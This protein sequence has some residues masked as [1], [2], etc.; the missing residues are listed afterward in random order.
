[1]HIFKKVPFA[2]PP[3]GDLRFALPKPPRRWEEVWNSKEYGPACMS[4]SSETSSP[5]KWVD[6]D[7]LHLNVFTSEACLESKNCAVAYYLHGGAI[8]FDS[9]VMFNDTVVI[10]AF[11]RKDVVIVVGAYRLGVFSHVIFKNES[12]VPYNLAMYDII[13]G[14]EFVQKEIEHFGGNNQ[15]VSVFGHSYG[16]AIVN[17]MYHSIHVDPENRLFQK[18]VAMSGPLKFNSLDFQL[19]G[20]RQLIDRARCNPPNRRPPFSENFR[21]SYALNCLKKLDQRVLL[22]YQRELEE[23][24]VKDQ[25][26][27]LLLAEP[28][29]QGK[30]IPELLSTSVRKIPYMTGTTSKELD[31]SNDPFELIEFLSF[32]N[33][34]QVRAKYFDDLKNGR[35]VSG[36]NHSEDTQGL[37]LST[38]ADAQTATRNGAQVY[39][40][41]YQYPKH[42]RH[43]DDLYYLLGVHK[44]EK[45]ENEEALSQ[46]YPE[47]FAQFFKTG[48]P[49]Q[50]WTRFNASCNNYFDINY[51][52]TS[53]VRPVMKMPYEKEVINYW[54]VGMKNFDEQVSMEKLKNSIPK[55]VPIS[56]RTFYDEPNSRRT[57]LFLM[58]AVA[59]FA[60]FVTLLHMYLVHKYGDVTTMRNN[61]YLINEKTPLYRRP[62]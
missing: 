6:E 38:W 23:E 33:M 54:T 25:F 39:L 34:N 17:A 15:R 52:N 51:N 41:S 2:E 57:F 45:D 49:S 9:A 3:V 28:L 4:N 5:Q 40:Y 21:D 13:S 26:S 1:M 16:G 11:P 48:R 58:G 32:K 19:D 24:G 20:T 46:L 35:L 59:V 50:E 47:Y 31:T 62:K 30:S 7:C 43:T 55:D 42:P 36:F 29:F 10:E 18:A 12:L 8:N 37:F 53:G 27:H 60:A 22:G 56:V 14:L 44:F 61:Y